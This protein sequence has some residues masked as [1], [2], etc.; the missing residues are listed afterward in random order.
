MIW[1]IVENCGKLKRDVD[2]WRKK[3]MNCSEAEP[4][5][6]QIDFEY[7]DLLFSVKIVI[8][9]KKIL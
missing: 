2:S 7:K 9:C 4:S 8:K 6:F 3:G 1:N 5:E